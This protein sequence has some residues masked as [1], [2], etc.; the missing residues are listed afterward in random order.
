MLEEYFIGIG[1][2]KYKAIQVFDWLYRKKIYDFNDFS[3][4]KK[5]IIDR[6]NSDFSND[7]T[8]SIECSICRK[9][10]K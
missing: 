7:F 3:N 2:K 5:S 9:Y 6:I 8:C 4:I 10:G 1:E